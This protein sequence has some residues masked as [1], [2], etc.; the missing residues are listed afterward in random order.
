[1]SS[2]SSL[3]QN[4]LYQSDLDG[5]VQWSVLCFSCLFEVLPTQQSKRSKLNSQTET[6]SAERTYLKWS[7]IP[8]L[9]WHTM[10]YVTWA[11]ISSQISSLTSQPQL[12]VFPAYWFPYCP[13]INRAHSCLRAFGSAISSARSIENDMVPALIPF[14]LLLKCCFITEGFPSFPRPQ[15]SFVFQHWSNMTSFACLWC[16]ACFPHL[17]ANFHSVTLELWLSLSS[18]VSLE[19]LVPG[20]DSLKI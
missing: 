6:L 3:H 7:R 18:A 17:S 5:Q 8:C 12:A 11:P 16:F 10:F 19:S 20:K 1:M 15:N 14:E 13:Q 9:L 2:M 4:H